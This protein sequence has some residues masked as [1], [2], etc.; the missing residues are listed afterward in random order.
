MVRALQLGPGLDAE[1]VDESLPRPRVLGQRLG[2][3][4]VAVEREQQLRAEALAQRFVRDEYLQLR[5]ELGV[6][7]ERKIGVDAR[8]ERHEPQL[9]EPRAVDLGLAA[10][11][12]KRVAQAVGGGVRLRGARGLDEVFEPREIDL[13]ARGSERVARRPP[14]DRVRA[15]RAP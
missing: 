4:A 3:A 10:P 9:G 5:D 14:H 2:L 1:L 7:A 6:P 8:L 11:Q 15:E 13:L 12:R